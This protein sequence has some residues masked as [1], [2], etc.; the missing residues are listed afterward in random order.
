MIKRWFFF[1]F[2]L[3]GFCSLIYQ[4]VWLRLAMASYGVTTLMISIVLSIFMAGL[5]MGSWGAGRLSKVLDQKPRLAVRLYA[6]AEL[7][8]GSSALVVPKGLQIGRSL[9]Q[10]GEGTAWGSLG[11]YLTASGLITITLLPYTIC[12]GATIPVAMVALRHQED[13][14]RSFSF[15]Y[16]A[17]VIGA[18]LGTLCSAFILIEIL[19]FRHT[20]MF[21]GVGNVLLAGSAFAVS[22][23]FAETIKESVEI[24]ILIEKKPRK[25]ILVF[26]FATG[27]I[28]MGLEIIWTRL[29]TPYIGTEVYAF[30]SILALYF[31]ATFIGSWLY[32]NTAPWGIKTPTTSTIWALCGLF[33]FIALLGTDPRLFQLNKTMRLFIG[34]GFFSGTLGYLTPM[35]VDLWSEGDSHRAGAAYAINVFG[36]I[37]G[38]ILAG[39]ILLPTLGERWSLAVLATPCFLIAFASLLHGKTEQSTIRDWTYPVLCLVGSMFVV[40]F[41]RD[42][43]SIFR[44]FEI[45][46][47]YTAT[48][49]AS[50]EGM[51][52]QLY[53]NGYGITSLTPVTKIMAHLPLAM[54]Q[55]APHNGLVICFGMGTGF[56]S[57]HSWGIQSTAVELVP[58]VP[59]LFSFFHNDAEQILKSP[60]SHIII[61]DG[62]RFLERTHETF[63]VITI[64]PPPPIPAA[65]S[66]LLYS[67]EFYEIIKKRLNHNGIVQQ[68]IPGG[69]PISQASFCKAFKQSFPFT[70]FYLSLQN[71]GIHCLASMIPLQPFDP[72]TISQKLPPRALDDLLEWTPR[73]TA[74]Q[75]FEQLHEISYDQIILSHPDVPSLE[76]DRPMNEYYFLRQL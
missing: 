73:L 63:D 46:R 2:L 25:E 24:K 53:I 33:A 45:R 76:D 66:S 68:W 9:I 20:L 15:L 55:D 19:G 30:A 65:G 48:S 5:A 34:V 23:S 43:E 50:G 56:R 42:L 70:R 47:D 37:L 74:P 18:T 57:M 6:V 29:F 11:H 1:F 7:F 21:A 51:H 28:S 54:L 38:P 62:R 27:L 41:T 36:C 39:F 35:L 61:D 17:N 72:K 60:F 49:I 26:L 40:L 8:I 4:V 52:R 13:S 12:M 59:E 16:L 14:K 75:L 44:K 22:W 64:D 71:C 67:R 69:D 32:R 3:S 31:I 58:S 10:V